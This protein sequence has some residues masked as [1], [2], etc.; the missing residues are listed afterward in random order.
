M[1]GP[2]VPKKAREQKR[3]EL[4]YRQKWAAGFTPPDVYEWFSNCYMM[5]CDD[6]YVWG[7]GDLHGPYDPDSTTQSNAKDFLIFCLLASRRHVVPPG[8]DW[9][10]FLKVA[11]QFVCYAFEKSD[12]KE[13]WGGENFFSTMTTGRPSL[14]HTAEVV[15]GSSATAAMNDAPHPDHI[16]ATEEILQDRFC[17]DDV[18][19]DNDPSISDA[20]YNEVGG[21]AAWEVFET[22]LGEKRAAR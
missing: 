7:G 10:A 8:W 9:L 14:R 19:E 17:L 3:R 21:R 11:S 16:K 1:V 15:Y 20:L 4:A 2:P 6:D 22:M 18:D 13:R 5:R 12:A